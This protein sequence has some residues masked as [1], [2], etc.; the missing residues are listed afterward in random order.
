MAQTCHYQL[1]N[2]L[3]NTLLRTLYIKY[4]HSIPPCIMFTRGDTSTTT[5]VLFTCNT[6]L[7]LSTVFS[8]QALPH[9]CSVHAKLIVLYLR[10]FLLFEV[11]LLPGLLYSFPVYF[12][13]TCPLSVRFA[14]VSFHCAVKPTPSHRTR[15]RINAV[16]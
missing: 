7:S 5:R 14:L 16:H 6:N 12:P 10:S 9:G 13:S 8:T 15:E 3:I 2:D 4:G 11:L 1:Q